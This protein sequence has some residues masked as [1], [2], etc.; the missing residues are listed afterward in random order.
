MTGTD[1]PLIVSCAR[2]GSMYGDSA[3]TA[4]T[5]GARPHAL[6]PPANPST[7]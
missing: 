5:P 2:K 3:S 7:V 4:R 6:Q 1:M